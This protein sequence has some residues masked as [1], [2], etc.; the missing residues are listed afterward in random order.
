MANLD[1]LDQKSL[2]KNHTI[3]QSTE[4]LNKL[5]SSVPEDNSS[6]S[7]DDISPI[8]LILCTA[9]PMIILIILFI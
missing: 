8:L 3:L 4:E 2:E 7:E 6:V 1:S 9:I 5:N